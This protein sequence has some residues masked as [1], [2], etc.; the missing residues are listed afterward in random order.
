MGSTTEEK[1]ELPQK[2][3][4]EYNFKEPIAIGT[5]SYWVGNR[6]GSLL[7]RNIYLRVFRGK[8][9]TVNLII[10]PGPPSDF[11]I[12]T[13]KANKII[14]DLKDVDLAFVNHHDPDGAYNVSY[15]QQKNLDLTVLC[16]E[17]TW[18][19]IKFYDL[20][21]QR[22]RAVESFE[23]HTLQLATGHILSFIPSPFCH[24]RGAVMLYD[25]ETRILYTG[26]LFSGLSYVKDFYADDRH[27]EG[28]KTFHQIY[29]PTREALKLA[30][31]NIRALD[32]LPLMFA[33]QHGSVI[34]RPWINYYLE[35]VES[36]S[37]GINLLTNSSQKDNYIAALNQLLLELSHILSPAKIVSALRV[38]QGDGSFSNMIHVDSRRGIIDINTDPPNALTIFLNSIRGQ[39]A[40]QVNLVETA[41]LKVLCERNIP[42]PKNLIKEKPKPPKLSGE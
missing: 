41:A 6:E 5:N 37:V 25:H 24:S 32:P 21:S 14:G 1:S 40:D 27:W 11:L 18:N 30:I 2:A 20:N 3:P 31:G 12:L 17:E 7:E 36:L 42:L 23:N 35:R 33:P 8:G 19:L 10:D 9:T 29:M 13:E 4:T 22:F 39:A 38:F 28:L 15:L 34:I 16:S 26:D